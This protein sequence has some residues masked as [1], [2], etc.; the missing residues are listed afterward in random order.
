VPGL[1]LEIIEPLKVC[2]EAQIK[3]FSEASL[4][5][6]EFGSGMHNPLFSSPETQV[7]ML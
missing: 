2:I 3:L 6:G 4:V 7:I 1:R 5:V